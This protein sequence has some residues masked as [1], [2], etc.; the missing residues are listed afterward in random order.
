MDRNS[1][2]IKFSYQAVMLA[3]CS[4]GVLALTHM[5]TL[6]LCQSDVTV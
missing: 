6:L 1:Y 3:G 5:V 4:L 2:F